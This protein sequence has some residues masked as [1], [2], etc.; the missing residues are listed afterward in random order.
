MDH[1]FS[2]ATA[3]P[4]DIFSQQIRQTPAQRQHARTQSVDVAQRKYEV[5][6]IDAQGRF[7]EFNT[8]ARAHSAFEDAF[9]ALGQNAIVQ[10]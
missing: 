10:I 1:S 6:Y 7:N 5:M 3:Q 8:I 2:T 9:S 4:I